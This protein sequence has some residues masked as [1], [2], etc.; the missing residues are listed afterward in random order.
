MCTLPIETKYNINTGVQNTSLLTKAGRKPPS[1]IGQQENGAK[2]KESSSAHCDSC[3]NSTE[4]NSER[5]IPIGRES[6]GNL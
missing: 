3:G 2:A 4:A 1:Q 5:T 6:Q